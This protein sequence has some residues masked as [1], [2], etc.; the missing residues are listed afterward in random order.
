MR[1]FTGIALPHEA[2]SRM[3]SL[4][5][6]LRPHASLAWT[7]K[8]KLH[9]TTKFI[10][11]WPEARLSELQ[12][13]LAEVRAPGPIEISIRRIGWLPNPRFPTI[14]YAGVGSTPALTAL[15]SATDTALMPLGV[16]KEERIFRP[17]VTL[18]RVRDRRRT[19]LTPL[20]TALNP[21]ELADFAHFHAPAFHLYLSDSGQYTKLS[22]YPLPSA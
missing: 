16:A 11:E 4:I 3:M 22:D 20:R 10:G 7:P 19:N 12:Q 14:L 8:D 1:L 15:A 6:E 21:H 2:E 17:H 18:G 5:G 9:I 13:A